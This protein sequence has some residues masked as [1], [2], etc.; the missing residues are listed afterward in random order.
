MNSEGSM[1]IAL[2]PT[3]EQGRWTADVSFTYT[4]ADVKCK[5]VSVKV[6]DGKVELVYDFEIGDF[7]G[8]STLT[9][10]ISATEI[11][12]T[13]HTKGADGSDVDQG[14]VKATVAK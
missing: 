3:A 9:G 7:Q 14:T 1:K 11:S 5:T 8:R 10:N 12:A 4:G 2:T 13:Y 6:A